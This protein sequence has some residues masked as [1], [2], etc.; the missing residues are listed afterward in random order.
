MPKPP[1]MPK[2][3]ETVSGPKPMAPAMGGRL[4]QR[5]GLGIGD[6]I[7]PGPIKPSAPPPKAISAAIGDTSAREHRS[8]RFSDLDFLDSTGEQEQAFDNGAMPPR[9]SPALGPG[10]PVRPPS[11]LGAPSIIGDLGSAPDWGSGAG[12][13]HLSDEPDS[14]GGHPQ[15]DDPEWTARRE[16]AGS[17]R[18]LGNPS[19]PPPPLVAGP[20]VADDSSGEGWGGHPMLDN[21][22]SNA[23]G[24]DQFSAGPGM[25]HQAPTAR[26]GYMFRRLSLYR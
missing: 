6:Q 14:W 18:R 16:V 10:R 19:N 15:L 13:N 9:Q 25:P 5:R 24:D 26:H 2:L 7:G 12:Q 8:S 17:F 21:N 1:S 20:R 3:P 4:K 11:P 23:A 22:W